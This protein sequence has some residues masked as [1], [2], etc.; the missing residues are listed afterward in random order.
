[1]RRALQ[2]AAS[3]LTIGLMRNRRDKTL[4]VSGMDSG[5]VQWPMAGGRN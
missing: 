3:P 2:G 5:D 1:V 4:T